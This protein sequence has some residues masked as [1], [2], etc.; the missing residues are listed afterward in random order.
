MCFPEKTPHYMQEVVHSAKFRYEF[1]ALSFEIRFIQ[2]CEKVMRAKYANFVL[3]P[4]ELSTKLRSKIRA[5]FRD[6]S[7][8]NSLKQREKIRRI[9]ETSAKIRSKNKEKIRRIFETSAKNQKR[10]FAS[11]TRNFLVWFV[12]IDHISIGYSVL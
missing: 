1:I 4:C 7:S 8:E 11:C 6:V 2:Y 9:F 5:S 3:C 12:K 10:N